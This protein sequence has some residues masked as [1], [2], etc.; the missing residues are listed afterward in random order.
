MVA[1]VLV[2]LFGLYPHLRWSIKLGELAW[3]Y[4]SYD[5]GYYG[6][7]SMTEL[8]ASRGLSELV[9]HGLY[10]FSGS[11]TQLA[12][13]L[14]DFF[15]PLGVTLACCYLVRPL[16]VTAGG[17]VAGA[18]FVITSAEC[19][20]LR[21]TS[22]PHSFLLGFLQGKVRAVGGIVA[23]IVQLDNQTSTF[24]LFRTPEPQVSWV[25]MFI[26]LGCALRVVLAPPGRL[27]KWGWLAI[28]SL[29]SGM[30]YVF[31]A[32]TVSGVFLLFSATAMKSHL[33]LAVKI[34]A[35]GLLIFAVCIGLSIYT[36]RQSSG[37]SVLF[38]SHRPVVMISAILGLIAVGFTVVRSHPQGLLHP[39]QLFA[40]ALGLTPLCMANQQL[41]TG[42]MIY[43]LNFENFGMAQVSALA[44]L[45]AIFGKTVVTQKPAVL[46]SLTRHAGWLRVA[47][48]ILFCLL[49]GGII[50]RSQVR[51]YAD[52]LAGNRL[53][54]SY[55]F[56]LKSLP[57]TDA[58]IACDD[59]FQ[60]DT[61][62]IRLGRRP[63]YLIAREMTF[64]KPIGRLKSPNDI[65]A[66]S[67]E[68]R[69]TLYQ[70]LALTGVS[71]EALSQRFAAITDP[72]N[73]SWEDR[74]MLGGFLYNHAD[75]WAPL[76][77]GRDAKLKWIEAQKT[78]IVDDYAEFLRN[79]SL[80]TRPV[81]FVMR[82]DKVPPPFLADRQARQL[83]IPPTT[84]LIP[85][86]AYQI[87]GGS[88]R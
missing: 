21:S 71:P 16:F 30:S 72:D 77:H 61:L 64:M 81:V 28:L 88:A 45:T 2:G 36:A 39:V 47:C 65:P 62:A 50:L 34:G 63:E 17:M 48:P 74:F 32:L 85:M 19:L 46:E 82:Q 26:V 57:A 4:N 69:R 67:S 70:Y 27:P 37:D 6:W 24:W 40:I 87:E 7:S 76:T 56:A 73:P 52:H 55:E 10:F 23:D 8:T 79:G 84:S 5:E 25:I 53:E 66:N 33:R 38:A 29:L 14:A 31:C 18:L 75:F 15:L 20:A 51:G 68:P 22:I 11:N 1:A 78:I 12:M 13:I 86:K 42:R 83:P 3:F 41:L 58:L 9:M 59:F 54:K 43:L 35:S 60:T 44:L 80:L 49:M